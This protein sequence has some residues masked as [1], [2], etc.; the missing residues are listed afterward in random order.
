MHFTPSLLSL[1]EGSKRHIWTSLD[2]W[3]AE[4]FC[5]PHFWVGGRKRHDWTGLGLFDANQFT[6]TFHSPMWK[7]L[8]FLQVNSIRGKLVQQ[9]LL[10][11]PGSYKGSRKW[12]KKEFKSFWAHS[13]H[14]VVVARVSLALHH[15]N[16]KSSKWTQKEFRCLLSML[17]NP[18]VEIQ[19]R[20]SLGLGVSLFD[21]QI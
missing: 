7:S 11:S 21:R 5:S 20:V 12:N 18:V 17:A 4:V 9:W 19:L 2:L 1:G 13:C 10:F 3:N 15:C 14:T 6:D 8:W 16:N